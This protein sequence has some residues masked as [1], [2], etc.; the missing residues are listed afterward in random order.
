M[1]NGSEEGWAFLP[2][3]A[4]RSRMG[5]YSN[6]CVKTY[7]AATSDIWKD[8]SH[9]NNLH[10]YCKYYIAKGFPILP[11]RWFTAR[12]PKAMSAARR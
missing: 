2:T 3:S 12:E 1:F 11:E 6:R 5:T 9:K 7:M 4:I 8:R 10:P